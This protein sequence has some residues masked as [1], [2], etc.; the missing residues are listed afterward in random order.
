MN[1]LSLA[2]EPLVPLPFLVAAAVAA[3]A[4]AALLVLARMRGAW[5][6]AL[7]LAA[8]VLALANPVAESEER[9]ALTSVVAL[10]VDRSQSQGMDGRE[11]RT[12][13]AVAA[14]EERLARFPEFELRTVETA[15]SGDETRVFEALD[16]AL[17]DV[18]P[19]RVA[20]ALLV[21]DGQ[22][23]DVPGNGGRGWPVH[24]LLTGR[25]GERDRRVEMRASPR[26][27]IV[28]E[29]QEIV[30]RVTDDGEA[31]NAPAVVT[32]RVNGEIIA[33]ETVALDTD[34]PTPFE[35]P[36]GGRNIVEVAVEPIE[37][38]ITRAN[39]RAVAEVDGIRENLRVLL[40]SGEPHSG[41]RTWRNLLKADPSVDLVHFTIL[42][43][44]EK[45]DGTPINELS[46]I[47]FPTRELFLE[48]IDEFDLIILDRYQRR[49]VLP[50]IYFDN[51]ARYVENGGA[52]L[53]AAGPDFAGPLSVASTPLYPALPAFP[54]GAM[55]E[56]PFHPTLSE[57]GAKH[58][59]TRDLPGAR[60]D[61]PEWGRWFR[62]VDAEV[63]EGDTVMEGPDGAPLL[64]LDR[65]G[66]GR[67]AL[68]LSDHGWLWARG[69]EGG[70]PH[71]PLYRRMAHWLMGEPELEEEALVARE[72]SGDLVVRRQTMGEEAGAASLIAPDGGAADL[73][74]SPVAPGRFEG[75]VESAATGLWQVASDELRALAYVGDPDAPELRETITTARLLAPV[76]EA[77]GGVVRP[78]FASD[79]LALPNILP[80]RAGAPTAGR[81]WI[82][83]RRTDET[84][85]RGVD[86]LPLF[87]GF[88]GLAVL[89]AA[90][91]GL[92]W[93]EGR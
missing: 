47:A 55:L 63:V 18:P 34:Y 15:V 52:L 10:V 43:P 70:G 2:F 36:R 91:G 51:I 72:A 48:K 26:F 25:E 50:V 44:P 11:A 27:G 41:E 38:E 53:V 37:G 54:S 9:D 56:R 49:G 5:L 14:I 71:V 81:G 57:D 67:V 76:A 20:G 73:A 16:A 42:R 24:A 83:L 86:R 7:A 32:V 65:Y 45:Q 3:L 30:W 40:V 19:A 87:G 13:E 12:D 4:L 84:V 31:T 58:P 23:H 78:A 33:R 75:R 35:V 1:T 68:M 46:L 21:T 60:S 28:G 89:L 82:G 66:E 64:V 62:S 74:L 69:V 29:I 59:V 93:R 92:W 6:R 88:L 77:S 90:L 17:A 61:P 79:A 22:V 80:V 8:L 39:N 85:L